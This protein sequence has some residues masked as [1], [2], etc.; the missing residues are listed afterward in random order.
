[1]LKKL[2]GI[3]I[4]L[5]FLLVKHVS[6]FTVTDHKQTVSIH[7]TDQ[8]TENSEEEKELKNL[9]LTD[10]VF[11]HQPIVDLAHTLTSKR[12]NYSFVSRTVT[13]V[14]SLPYPPPEI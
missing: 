9:E 2:T 3:L 14:I 11:I 10:D 5:S 6:L 1:M 7:H 4:L 8:D 13:S 12:V